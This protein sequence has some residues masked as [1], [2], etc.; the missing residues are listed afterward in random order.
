MARRLD[1]AE[2]TAKLHWLDHLNV[3]GAVYD[4]RQARGEPWERE[5][6]ARLLFCLRSAGC[7]FAGGYILGAGPC[8]PEVVEALRLLAAGDD[9]DALV[10]LDGLLLRGVEEDP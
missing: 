5:Q 9:D 10:V 6:R 8:R 3:G 7:T 4:Y 1:S 2:P